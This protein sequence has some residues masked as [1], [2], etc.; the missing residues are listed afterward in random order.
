MAAKRSTAAVT[1]R[2]CRPNGPGGLVLVACAA[3]APM[4]LVGACDRAPGSSPA[5][6]PASPDERGQAATQPAGSDSGRA[7][8]LSGHPG[9]EGSGARGDEEEGG[10][11]RRPGPRIENAALGAS[12]RRAAD[13]IRD[14][15]RL[16]YWDSLTAH[17][18]TVRVSTRS[19]TV[20][21][22][23]HLADS[24]YTAV[25]DDAGRGLLCDIVVFP[26]AVKEDIAR[27]RLYESQGRLGAPLPT[28][29]QF[30]AVVLGH[31]LAHCARGGRPGE[32][33]SLRWERRIL[34]G[35]REEKV[36]SAPQG[37]DSPGGGP[38]P[39]R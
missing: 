8:R 12:H 26:R 28:L 34:R 25:I 11:A 14:L 13:A 31:E 32:K 18:Y 5:A 15:R 17:L 6:P 23:A 4:L 33:L 27:Q 10:S 38:R 16:G 36:S 35:L 37:G 24:L 19:S 1:P 7:E 2:P 20:P 9:A 39:V 29:R 21:G 30:W 22:D 3:L